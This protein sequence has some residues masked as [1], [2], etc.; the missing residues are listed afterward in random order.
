MEEALKDSILGALE[1]VIDPELGIDIVN[2]GLVYKVDLD[3]DGLCTVEMTL[4]SI[5]CP[6]GPQIVDQVKTALGEL[7]EIKETEVNIV[8]NPPWNKDM[9]SR[10]AKIALGVS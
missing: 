7:P 2:L 3:D 1:N 10:Y 4:T 8:W 5:G 9:M 6:L